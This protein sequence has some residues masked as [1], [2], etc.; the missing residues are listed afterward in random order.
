MTDRSRCGIR[1]YR[2]YLWLGPAVQDSHIG[3]TMVF[4]GL[5]HRMVLAC[6]HGWLGMDGYV[7]DSLMGSILIVDTG[8]I[9]WI[10]L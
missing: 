2:L 10:G 8:S 3:V 9:A 7:M 5:T 6:Q 1:P 4:P